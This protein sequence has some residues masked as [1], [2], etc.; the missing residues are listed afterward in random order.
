[1]RFRVTEGGLEPSAIAR[2]IFPPSSSVDITSD[3]APRTTRNES[4]GKA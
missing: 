4:G 1:M 2:G 3:C